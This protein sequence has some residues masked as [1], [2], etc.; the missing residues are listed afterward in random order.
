MA[1][2]SYIND[3]SSVYPGLLDLKA[4]VSTAK[5]AGPLVPMAVVDSQTSVHGL[6]TG[7]K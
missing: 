4:G 3:P 2:Y 7:G 1:T 6:T 5:Q